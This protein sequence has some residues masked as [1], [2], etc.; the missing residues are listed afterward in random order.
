VIESLVER[1]VSSR[2][3]ELVERKGIGHP[4]TMCDALVK[5]AA[6]ALNCLYVN[7]L[8]ASAHYDLDK[9]LLAGRDRAEPPR[10]G[11]AALVAH[12]LDPWP[13]RRGD[14]APVRRCDRSMVA[15]GVV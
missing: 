5:A 6:V 13:V 15:E 8:G 11:R 1:P 14:D 12:E 9:A 4:D 2:R 7:R 10:R 3:L